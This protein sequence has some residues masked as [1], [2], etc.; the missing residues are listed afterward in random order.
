MAKTGLGSSEV[1]ANMDSDLV[2]LE[3]AAKDIGE[4]LNALAMALLEYV[5]SI[6]RS[7]PADK[8]SEVMPGLGNS[9]YTVVHHLLGS[10]RYWIGEVVGGQE[11]GRIR[12]DEFAAQG[13]IEDLELRAADTL[14]RLSGTFENLNSS[15]LQP[16]DI[17]LSRGVLS[18]GVLPPEGRTHIWVL[19]HDLAHIGYHLGQLRLMQKLHGLSDPTMH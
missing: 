7:F 9:P 12:Q 3:R 6:A 17:D 4:D 15:A 11:T 18:W 14:E 1:E 10:A 8:L 5:M 19:A 13:T 16:Q 2:K